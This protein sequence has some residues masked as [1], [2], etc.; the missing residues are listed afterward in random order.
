M[1]VA[2]ALKSL[3]DNDDDDEHITRQLA[4]AVLSFIP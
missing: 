3:S 2:N 4:C 1:A